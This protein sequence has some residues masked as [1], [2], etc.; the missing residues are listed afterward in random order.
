MELVE[1]SVCFTRIL[2]VSWPSFTRA[3]TTRS[4]ENKI[5]VTTENESKKSSTNIYTHLI[6]LFSLSFFSFEIESR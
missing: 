1:E 3:L 6:S 4:R 2:S 5:A